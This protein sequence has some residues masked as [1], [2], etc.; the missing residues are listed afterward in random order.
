MNQ[1]YL[2]PANSKKQ[3][4]IF[5]FLLPIDLAIICVAVG[6]TFILLAILPVT[7]LWGYCGSI[8]SVS[9]T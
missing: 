7:E 1:T 2:V 6:A 5:G 9:N 3:S 8:F 4:L